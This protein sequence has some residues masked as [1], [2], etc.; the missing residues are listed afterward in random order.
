MSQSNTKELR[1]KQ[2]SFFRETFSLHASPT[3]KKIVALKTLTA[4]KTAKLYYTKIKKCT[5]RQQYT[6]K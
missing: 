2:E 3:N 5:Q 1:K 6:V 4:K